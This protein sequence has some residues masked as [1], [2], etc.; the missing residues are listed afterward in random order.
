[1]LHQLTDVEAYL[2][3]VDSKNSDTSPDG[4]W[5]SPRTRTLRPYC[6]T[7]GSTYRKALSRASVSWI[8]TPYKDVGWTDKIE[9]IYQLWHE[10]L[11]QLFD[12]SPDN[13][14]GISL[15]G[16]RDS[17]TVLA[18]MKPYL[19]QTR[20][21]TYTASN[22][23]IGV[24]PKSFWQRTMV[25]VHNVLAQLEDHL[26]EDFHVRGNFV[27]MGRL[28]RGQLDIPD[29]RDR[30]APII[31]EVGRRRRPNMDVY[32]EFFWAKVVEY[33]DVYHL[34]NRSSRWYAEI[35]NETDRVFDSIVPVNVRRIY[36]VLA[37]TA[38]VW[39]Q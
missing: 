34:E 19:D 20:A 16:G 27:E 14:V 7:T 37:R 18:H 8:P 4:M 25:T 3:P 30:L 29:Q 31:R 23:E 24:A 6:R 39:H 38:G 22:V 13:P 12:M 2:C 33:T 10:Q 15:S 1:M 36:D 11:Q 28:I 5:V 21:F 9:T 35:A 26:P 17:R 32:P